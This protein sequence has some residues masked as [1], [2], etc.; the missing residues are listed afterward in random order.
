MGRPKAEVTQQHRRQLFEVAD[1]QAGYFSAKQAEAAGFSR[2][3]QHHYA[4]LGE[5]LH[6]ERGI[7]RLRDYP[8]GNADQFARL[9]LW[10]RDLHDQP[11]AVVSHDTALRHHDLSDHD[12]SRVHLT[13]PPGFR[14]VPPRGV[15]LHRARLAPQDTQP[16]GGYRVTTPARTLLDLAD[17]PLSPEH[18]HRAVQEASARGLIRPRRLL[19]AAQDLPP[20]ARRRLLSALEAL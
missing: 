9:T 4:R 12:P 16:A 14:K 1:G 5:W 10:S 13:V 19:A 6:P 3:L 8:E 2:R 15:V 18:L 11:Q 7:Y 20:A 17:S